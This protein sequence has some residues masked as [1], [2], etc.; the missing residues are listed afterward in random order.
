MPRRL[1][2][3]GERFEKRCLLV[4]REVCKA[5]LVSGL[6]RRVS[7][8]ELGSLPVMGIGFV[9]KNIFAR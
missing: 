2:L 8:G 4:Q 1:L 3:V 6:R 9:I 7:Q 5:P